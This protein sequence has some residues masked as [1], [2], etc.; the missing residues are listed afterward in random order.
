MFQRYR[1]LRR[2]FAGRSHRVIRKGEKTD[3]E[4]NLSQLV[5][6]GIFA[7]PPSD[8]VPIHDASLFAVV[9]WISS[10]LVASAFQCH[11]VLWHR[12]ACRSLCRGLRLASSLLSDLVGGVGIGAA[13]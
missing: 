10:S 7:A 9:V 5:R 13:N 3:A 4:D 8:G 2:P 6:I 11:F 12:P 1:I